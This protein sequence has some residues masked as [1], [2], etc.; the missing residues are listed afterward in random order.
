MRGRKRVIIRRI[1]DE[2]RGR[3]DRVNLKLCYSFS[4]DTNRGSRR[5]MGGMEGNIQ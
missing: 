3:G 1:G 4:S 2:R 5:H